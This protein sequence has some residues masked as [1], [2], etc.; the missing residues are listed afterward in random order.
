MY[1]ISYKKSVEKDLKP[2]PKKSLT[3]IVL[4][5]QE[6]AINPTPVGCSKLKGYNNAYRLRIGNYRVVYVINDGELI[7]L[8]IRVA[9]RK[10]VYKN[11]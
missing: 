2:I 9:H 11:L 6:L 8:I 7:V 3:Q 4:A 1:A 5:I 10:E